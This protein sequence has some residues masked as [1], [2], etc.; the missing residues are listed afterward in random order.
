MVSRDDWVEDITTCKNALFKLFLKVSIS[1]VKN[2]R[3]KWAGTK[4]LRFLLESQADT[5]DYFEPDVIIKEQTI[6]TKTNLT[7][8]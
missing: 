6:Y 4:N 2:A 3:Q 5:V 8:N 7:Q 1:V